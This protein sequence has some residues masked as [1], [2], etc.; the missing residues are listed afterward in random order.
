[1]NACDGCADDIPRD[2]CGYH[3]DPIPETDLEYVFYCTAVD[4]PTSNTDDTNE[5]FP[6]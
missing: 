3:R 5:E 4:V 6:F 2:A 1:M